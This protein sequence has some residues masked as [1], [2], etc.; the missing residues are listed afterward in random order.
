[1]YNIFAG[2]D[3]T[4]FLLS[5]GTCVFTF[6]GAQCESDGTVNLELTVAA[7]TM[8]INLKSNLDFQALPFVCV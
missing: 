6:I 4:P 5:S 3:T 8:K 2:L 1:M 7:V